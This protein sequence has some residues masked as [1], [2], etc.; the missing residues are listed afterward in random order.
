MGGLRRTGAIIE[1]TRIEGALLVRI[2]PPEG[3][4]ET[5]V[6]PLPGDDAADNALP[7]WYCQA[8]ADG[9]S[10]SFECTRS[11][12][13]AAPR[14]VSATLHQDAPSTEQ[15]AHDKTASDATSKSLKRA[16]EIMQPM[17]RRG[18]PDVTWQV[19]RTL[20][21]ADNVLRRFG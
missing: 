8:Q 20:R 17:A 12:P 10:V 3:K 1:V 15:R 21:R 9:T 18:Q 13:L 11:S 14:I 2:N 7:D 6:H 16:S 5:L 19:S 4:A